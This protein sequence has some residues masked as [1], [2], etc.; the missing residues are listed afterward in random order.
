MDAVTPNRDTGSSVETAASAA[1]WPRDADGTRQ[2][3]LAAARRR[4]ARD[5][6]T[7]T[8]VRDIATD[9]GVNVALINRYFT[10]KEGLFEACVTHA[11]ME[12]GSTG[13]KDV[14]VEGIVR[15]ILEHIA[16]SPSGEHSAQLLL[17]LQTSG[18]DRAELLRRE[19]LRGFAE[20]MATASG[21]RPGDPNSEEVILRAQIALS[22]TLGIVL[23]RSMSGLDPLAT[24]SDQELGRPLSE[25]LHLLLSPPQ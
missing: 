1:S 2:R 11:G 23:L 20:R 9:A 14:T 8:T 5:G 15:T 21:W 4:F 19:I 7:T 24:A 18:D 13:S 12:L 16:D 22:A 3:L 6:Y 25:L 10:S 17:L